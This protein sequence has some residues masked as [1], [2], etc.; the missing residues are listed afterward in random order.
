[1]FV[2]QISKSLISGR[3]ICIILPLKRFM[4]S[5]WEAFKGKTRVKHGQQIKPVE[6]S[7]L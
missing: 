5:P 4:D 7:D 1:M 6:W 2:V 3:A